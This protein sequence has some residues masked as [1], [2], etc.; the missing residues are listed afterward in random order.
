MRVVV[1]GATGNLGTSLVEAL[2]VE[3]RVD[4]IVGLARRRPAWSPPKTSFD[5]ADVRSSHLV[6]H[7]RDADVVVHLAWAFQPTHAPFTTWDVNVL[8]SIRVFE[9]A[10]RAGVGA[11]VYASS[12]GAYSPGAGRHVDESWPT[13][14]FPTAAYGR[15]KAYLERYLD[16]FRLREPQIRLAWLRPSFAFKRQSASEQRRIFAGPLLPRGLVRPGRLPI[17]PVPAGLRFQ[18]VHSHDVGEALRLAVLAG[19]ANGPF[20][21]AADPVI[22]ATVLAELLGTRPVTV[23]PV[24]ARAALGAAWRLRLVPADDALLDLLLHLPILD[25]SRIRQELGWKP[26]H[27]GIEALREL[28]DG[29]AEGAGG[30]TPPLHA[31]H[32]TVRQ[33]GR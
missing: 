33:S 5:D 27:T 23:P 6:E 2:S 24:T 20:N 13:H 11:I 1:T 30:P 22:D 15:E 29:L 31:D 18:A 26:R 9:A 25:S 19:E 21:V 28:I 7:F 32:P 12:V 10:A 8:G 14:G 16:A 3:P 17:L 4:Q